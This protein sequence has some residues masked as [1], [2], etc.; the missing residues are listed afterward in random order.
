MGFGAVAALAYVAAQAM[1]PKAPVV[2]VTRRR[3]VKAD[4]EA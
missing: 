4:E 2:A 1:K 3:P